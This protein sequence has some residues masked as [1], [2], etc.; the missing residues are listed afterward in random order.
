LTPPPEVRLKSSGDDRGGEEGRGGE[1]LTEP[2]R[3]SV[4][5]WR[6]A[7]MEDEI[8]S[9]VEQDEWFLQPYVALDHLRQHQLEPRTD[10][11]KPA[12]G[13][14]RPRM[15]KPEIR[16]S[17]TVVVYFS[18]RSYLDVIDLKKGWIE[19]NET[20]RKASNWSQH[21]VTVQWSL[22]CRKLNVDWKYDEIRVERC[23]AIDRPLVRWAPSGRYGGCGCFCEFSVRREQC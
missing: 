9:I 2:I 7:T 10:L 14:E 17:R 19:E 20:R 5:G 8:A 23:L 12:V 13:E 4:S 1:A 15:Q 3:M 6:M 16:I 21:K 18:S 11:M 22:A